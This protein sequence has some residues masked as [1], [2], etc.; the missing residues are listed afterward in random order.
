MFTRT[1][2][3]PFC[4]PQ[5]GIQNRLGAMFFALALFGWTAVTAVD[6]LVNSAELVGRE[7]RGH[8]HTHT[9]T[10][11]AQRVRSSPF[12][13]LQEAALSNP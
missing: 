10:H 4:A 11:H 7:A 2:A 9:H 6:G 3:T 13:P 5:V 8:T 12:A 1:I